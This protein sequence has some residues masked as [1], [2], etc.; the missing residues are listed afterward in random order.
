MEA[1]ACAGL[2]M[3]NDTQLAV[4]PSG[5]S[6][7]TE[8]ARLVGPRAEAAGDEMRDDVTD[9]ALLCRLVVGARIVAGDCHGPAAFAL[10]Q[11]LQ[12][13]RRVVDVPSGIEHRPDR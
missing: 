4:G 8:R 6:R 13:A 7:L 2:M 1:V 9:V 12:E 3:G 5:R 10:L 11:L